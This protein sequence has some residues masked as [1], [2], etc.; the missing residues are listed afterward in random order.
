MDTEKV[1]SE[2]QA[3]KLSKAQEF[4]LWLCFFCVTFAIALAVE[5]IYGDI[6][7]SFWRIARNAALYSA[8]YV[9]LQWFSVVIED[10]FKRFKNSRKSNK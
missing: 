1:N 3:L 4:L 2:N 8:G 10:W 7:L 5:V 6:P 9:L